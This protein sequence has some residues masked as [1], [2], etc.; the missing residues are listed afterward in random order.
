[1]KKYISILSF[2]IVHLFAYTQ[3]ERLVL[4]SQDILQEP[5]TGKTEVQSASRT[6][7]HLEDLPVTV[8]VVT[9]DEILKNGYLS[10]VD[11]LR[12]VPGIKVTQ[13]GSAIEGETFLMNGL[14]GNYYCKILVNDIP[15]QPSVVSGMPI[16]E[17]LPIRQAERIEI[18]FGPSSA[19]Y[20]GDALAGVINIVT[21]TS[22]RPVWSQADIS[23]GNYG[24]YNMNVMIGGKVGK[25]KNVL[26]Y[27]FYGSS[28]HYDDMNIKYD[29]PNLYN[30]NL[31][32]D[33]AQY[34]PNYKGDSTNPQLGRLPLNSRLLGFDLKFKGIRFIY[35]H[36][37]R[38]S[39]SSIGQSTNRYAYYNPLSYWG[40]KIDRYAINYQYTWGKISSTTNLS[41][42]QYR[43]DDQSSF[44]LIDDYGKQGKVYK[45]AASDDLFAEEILTWSIKSNLELT[46]GLSAQYSG[47]LPKTND[48][49]EPFETG[50]YKPFAESVDVADSVLGQF[51]FN[52]LVF[53]NLAGF[54][55]IFYKVGKFSMIGGARIDE[56][57]MFGSSMSPRIGFLYKLTDELSL[58]TSYGKGFRAPS[59]YY[60]YNSIAYATQDGIFYENVPNTDVSP[61]KFHEVDLGLRYYP[62]KNLSTELVVLYHFLNN[63]ITNSLKI[64]DPEKYPNAANIFA[65]AAVN[66]DRS[67]AEILMAQAIF[68]AKNIIEKIKLNS[69][70]FVTWSKGKEILP[71]DLGTLNDYRNYPNWLVQFNFD[72]E[73]IENWTFIFNNTYS[74]SWKKRFFPFD[75][76]TMELLGLPTETKGYYTLDFI[77][78]YRIDN[79][80]QAFM[81]M[82]N[83]FDNEYGGTDATGSLFDLVYN[84]QYGRYFRF[85]L[86][87][88]ME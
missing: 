1:M 61:E 58:R 25:R 64:V 11:V 5:S 81:N 67:Q 59:L 55:Q 51:G 62:T 45:Y 41:Y 8:Y 53:H 84:P 48:L 88:R 49:N 19:L 43:L 36:M 74:S 60:V 82:N 44:Q 78:R 73:P 68:R 87:F 72:I 12:D 83:V 13:P 75:L 63:N 29:I 56:H 33:S 39:H 38:N 85:G 71:N 65:L 14:Y 15:I 10:L 35:S 50:K 69:D 57:S 6:E 9:R 23:V 17:Q 52:P 2:L 66:D 31:Y 4:D 16:G 28:G 86:I 46:G 27:S 76:P 42:L 21:K 70:L 26:E 40:E 22:D 30:P 54:I 3:Q 80:F 7:Q 24:F 47:N 77:V 34:A 37:Y 32:G 79:N 20:G 18:I